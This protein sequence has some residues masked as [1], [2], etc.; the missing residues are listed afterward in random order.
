[1][2][3]SMKKTTLMTGHILMLRDDDSQIRFSVLPG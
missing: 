2:D 3:T 1:M